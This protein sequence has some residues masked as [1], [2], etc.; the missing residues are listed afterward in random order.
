MVVVVVVAVVLIPEDLDD[1][2]KCSPLGNL[3]FRSLMLE[4]LGKPR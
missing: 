4:S 1:T 2:D 3:F